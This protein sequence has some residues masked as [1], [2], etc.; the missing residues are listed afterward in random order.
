METEK[1]KRYEEAL[2]YIALVAMKQECHPMKFNTLDTEC[3]FCL[4]YLALNDGS[5]GKSFNYKALA[6]EMRKHP[7]FTT[8]TI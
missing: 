6:E 2:D 3:I 8:D 7:P 5:H 1:I 4:A